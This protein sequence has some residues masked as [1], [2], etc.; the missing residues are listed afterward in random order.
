MCVTFDFG[1][2]KN[3]N[4]FYFIGKDVKR[5]KQII[6]PSTTLKYTTSMSETHKFMKWFLQDLWTLSS[7]AVRMCWSLESFPN[8]TWCHMEKRWIV[9]DRQIYNIHKCRT[10]HKFCN[11]V[12]K[13][14]SNDIPF[15]ILFISHW[16]LC[17]LPSLS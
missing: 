10:T 9:S 2:G 8:P 14:I 7:W 11:L 12:I 17:L 13:H 4:N 1:K 16:T 6:S 15:S 3:K 5:I